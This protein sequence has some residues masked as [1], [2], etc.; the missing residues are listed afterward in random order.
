MGFL[1]ENMKSNRRINVILAAV[2]G[3]LLGS[4]LGMGILLGLIPYLQ[5]VQE[6]EI[7]AQE[8]P[9]LSLPNIGEN[10][11]VAFSAPPDVQVAKSI[12]AVITGYSSTVQQTDDTPFITA[13]GTQVRDG[14]V[15]NNY[16][17]IGTRI[18]IPYLFGDKVF[19][20][21][22]RMYWEK[23][24]YHIDI[25]FPSYLEAVNFGKKTTYVEILQN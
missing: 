18:R 16:F 20:I 3:V 2:T 15:A 7:L 14:I 10:T 8:G 11:L 13:S 17:P 6:A 5:N 22:D 4:L 12:Q 23:S 1:S 21:E 25:W 9:S 19:T 24:N